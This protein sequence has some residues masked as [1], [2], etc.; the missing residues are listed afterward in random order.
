MDSKRG[1]LALDTP[2]LAPRFV[3]AV[4]AH[5]TVE[6]LMDECV[7]LVATLQLHCLFVTR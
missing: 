2:A 4:Q 5:N 3:R 6:L 7:K 1:W